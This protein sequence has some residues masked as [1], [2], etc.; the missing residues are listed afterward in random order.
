MLLGTAFYQAPFHEHESPVALLWMEG[1]II[2]ELAV[3]PKG[4]RRVTKNNSARAETPRE[5]SVHRKLTRGFVV[6]E[7][8]F[9]PGR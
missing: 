9:G 7:F 3:A 5:F 2:N 8:Q 6:S 4:A 1:L